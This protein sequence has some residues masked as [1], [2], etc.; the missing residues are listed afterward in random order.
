MDIIKSEIKFSYRIALNKFEDAEYLIIFFW[1]NIY[2]TF[3]V[4]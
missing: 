4:A 1:L 3:K 2:L